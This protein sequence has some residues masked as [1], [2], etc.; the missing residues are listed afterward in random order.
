MP[1]RLHNIEIKYTT[2]YISVIGHREKDSLPI[3]DTNNLY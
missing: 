2:H 1:I 3:R